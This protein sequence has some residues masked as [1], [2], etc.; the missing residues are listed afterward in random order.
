VL[1]LARACTGP[2]PRANASA[3]FALLVITQPILAN[4]GSP[5]RSGSPASRVV[6]SP[7]C[8]AD[9]RVQA[10]RGQS[11]ADRAI[12][13]RALTAGHR[14]RLRTGHLAVAYRQ[15]GEPVGARRG[16][17]R[18]RPGVHISRNDCV[19]AVRRDRGAGHARWFCGASGARPQQCGPRAGCRGGGDQKRRQDPRAAT[20]PSGLA[21]TANERCVGC[22]RRQRYTIPEGPRVVARWPSLAGRS[23]R[24][25][26]PNVLARPVHR[27][28][29]CGQRRL[30]LVP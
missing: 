20:A 3:S 22:P 24:P 9:F 14:A 28:S 1:R 10:E 18:S 2:R 21:W 13:S 25:L 27:P 4:S 16:L 5:R 29:H 30:M 6:G 23:P 8:L 26:A 17:R 19:L 15:H 7:R 12:D 11:A